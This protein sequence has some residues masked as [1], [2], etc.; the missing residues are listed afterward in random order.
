MSDTSD[1]FNVLVDIAQRNIHNA[2]GL[3]AQIDITPHWS[4][5]GF[6]LGGNRMVAPMGEVAEILHVPEFTRLPS[7]QPWIRGVSNVRGR[8]LPLMDLED[9]FGAKH[10]T[11]RRRRRVL[12]LDRGE[13]YSGL[14][15][16]EVF[17]MQH[18]PIDTFVG[19]N[20]ED[21]GQSEPFVRGHY[22][23]G[24]YSWSVFSP[25]LLAQD[26]RFLNAAEN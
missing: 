3:P 4:G 6:S 9:F 16:D 15:V 24:R 1:A 5:L 10:Q 20:V 2:K 18:F 14:I 11:N 22:K 13:L 26:P 17:G 7:V 8:L 25:F 19:E 23:L 12:V 21:L